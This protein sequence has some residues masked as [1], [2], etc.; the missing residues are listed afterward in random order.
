[1]KRGAIVKEYLGDSI[2]TIVLD[3]SERVSIFNLNKSEAVEG[4]TG[5]F[6]PQV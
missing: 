4:E 5:K 1:M 3:R 2:S 6:N